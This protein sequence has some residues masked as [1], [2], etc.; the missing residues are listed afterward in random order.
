MEVPKFTQLGLSRFWGPITLC[1]D[2]RLRWSL[3][4]S[5]SPRWDLFNG[6]S[7]TTCMQVNLGDSR[8]L[9]VGSQIVN[10][11]PSLFFGYNLW[12]KCSNRSCELILDIY[13]PKDFQ[14]YKEVFNPMGFDLFNCFLKIQKS[15]GT[16]TPKMGVHLGVWRFIL[17]RFL[18]PPGA[19]N[20]IPGLR[21]WLAPL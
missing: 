6:L 7:H 9:V 17:S 13:V 10:L 14:W 11:T 21:T 1:A 8:L 4:K 18:A 3:K 15:I 2:I 16:P 5:C 19:W 12:I 20:V